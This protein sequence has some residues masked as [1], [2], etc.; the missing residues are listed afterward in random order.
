MAK[1]INEMSEYLFVNT[2]LQDVSDLYLSFTKK[3]KKKNN[4]EIQCFFQFHSRMKAQHAMYTAIKL[5]VDT[6]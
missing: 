2:L 3:I 5:Y 6:P 4:P 1:Q